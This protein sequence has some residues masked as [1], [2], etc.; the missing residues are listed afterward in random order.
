[1]ADEAELAPT[2]AG[3]E[4]VQ[5]ETNEVEQTEAVE[6]A[7]APESTEGKPKEVPAEDKAKAEAEESERKSRNERRRE[8]K[9][10]MQAD[11]KE[12]Q[13]A[14]EEARRKLEKQKEAAARLPKPKEGDYQSYEEYQAAL[15]SWGAVSALDSRQTAE[16][17]E[18]AKQ[19]FDKLEQAKHLQQQQVAQDWAAQQAEGRVKYPDFDEK[20]LSAAGKFTNENIAQ[21]L[22]QSDM[23]ADVAYRIATDPEVAAEYAAIEA[24]N[25]VIGAARLIG[26]LEAQATAP[27]PKTVTEAP[28]PVSP[29]RPAATPS[30]DPG[31]MTPA[32]YD[33]WRE[34]GGTFKIGA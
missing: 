21:V 25:D 28:D 3:S 17:E 29:V 32:E 27:K 11:L 5:P 1:M 26:R 24:Q 6:A 33:E 12:A 30:K 7:E 9:Q 23:A 31:K 34:K 16:L 18:A 2:E 13:E 20:V 22:V 19:H 8:A 15:S 10:R 4:V 14:A